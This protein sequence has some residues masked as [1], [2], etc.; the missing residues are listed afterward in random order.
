VIRRRSG[1]ER[2]EHRS[3]GGARQI[4]H[5]GEIFLTDVDLDRG[6]VGGVCC[7]FIAA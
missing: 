6:G 7:G 1:F 5:R 2:F 3:G 4:D